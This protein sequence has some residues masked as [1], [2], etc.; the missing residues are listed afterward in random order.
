MCKVEIKLSKANNVKKNVRRKSKK[1][2]RKINFSFNA[3][4]SLT[5]VIC[6]KIAISVALTDWRLLPETIEICRYI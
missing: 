6:C 1:K 4:T 3:C 2:E 5:A